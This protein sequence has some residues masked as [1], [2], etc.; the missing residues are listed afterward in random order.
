[1]NPDVET[2]VQ[3]GKWLSMVDHIRNNRIE[4]LLVIGLAHLM[5]LTSKAYSHVSGVCI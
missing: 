3:A 4:Y 5:G 1:M 2:A